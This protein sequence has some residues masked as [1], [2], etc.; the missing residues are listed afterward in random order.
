MVVDGESIVANVTN[1]IHFNKITSSIIN[2]CEFSK[3]TEDGCYREGFTTCQAI[4][5]NGNISKILTNIDNIIFPNGDVAKELCHYLISQCLYALEEIKNLS[6]QDRL[7]I[8][9][10]IDTET[11]KILQQLT[12]QHKILA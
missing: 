6:Q 9:G 5:E 10:L 8:H 12:D 7:K 11:T 2:K 3:L 1:F 4:I